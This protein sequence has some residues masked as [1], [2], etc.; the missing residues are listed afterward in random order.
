M[1]II[2][3]Q[4]DLIIK[5][6]ETDNETSTPA[7]Q[8]SEDFK[9]SKSVLVDRSP[10]FK[11]MLTSPNFVEHSTNEVTLKGDRIVSMEIWFKCMSASSHARSCSRK[12]NNSKQYFIESRLKIFTTYQSQRSGI[13]LRHVTSMIWILATSMPGLQHG[14]TIETF[15]SSIPLCFSTRAGGLT[16]RRALAS[17]QRK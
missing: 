15:C 8:T 13:W 11:A 5:I 2:D 14:M 10:V 6:V 9:V 7:L 3:E 17:L 1:I 4:G 12:R 16:M